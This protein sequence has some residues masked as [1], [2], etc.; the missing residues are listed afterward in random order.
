MKHEREFTLPL[1]GLSLGLKQYGFE[2]GADF[3]ASET[4]DDII[5]GKLDVQLELDKR[6]NMIQLH[7][8]LEGWLEVICDR[9]G[10]NYQQAVKGSQSL[11]LKYGDHYEEESDEIFIIP[12]DLHEFD[13]R[14][15]LYEYSV[16]TLPFRKIHPNK[17]DGSSGCNQ[18]VLNRLEQLKP[19]ENI[20]PRWEALRKLNHLS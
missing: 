10:D 3:Y 14:Q 6:E 9:C 4:Y 2:L 13:I 7:F 5:S 17:T 18:E 11:I 16:L 20:D 1:A 19:H 15:L 12:A 8:K